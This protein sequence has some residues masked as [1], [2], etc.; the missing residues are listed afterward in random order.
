MNA[1]SFKREVLNLVSLE[2]KKLSDNYLEYKI[3]CQKNC[4]VPNQD[5]EVRVKMMEEILT[6]LAKKIKDLPEQ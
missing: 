1:A 5:A 4:I 6:S 3:A 2:V